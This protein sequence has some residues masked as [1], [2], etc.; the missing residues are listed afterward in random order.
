MAYRDFHDVPRLTLVED[1][2]CGFRVL[3]CR[4]DD[5]SDDYP[6]AYEFFFAGREHRQAIGFLDSRD[7]DI[8]RACVARIPVA[9]VEFDP[10]RRC[11]LR[12]AHARLPAPLP[13]KSGIRP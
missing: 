2:D 5:G 7:E 12:V 1:D 4:F 13:R 10:T 8:R 6:D 3:D 9:R 11:R